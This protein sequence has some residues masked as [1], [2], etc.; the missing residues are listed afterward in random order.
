MHAAAAEEIR[1]GHAASVAEAAL[2]LRGQRMLDAE[3]FQRILWR[4]RDEIVRMIERD[5]E[6]AAL[7]AAMAEALRPFARCARILAE[8]HNAV[9]LSLPADTPTGRTFVQ[10]RPADFRRA[11]SVM[12]AVAP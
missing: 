2:A 7:I 5:A 4:H 3:A 8:G 10:L 6:Q 12:E 1:L 9:L 11:A